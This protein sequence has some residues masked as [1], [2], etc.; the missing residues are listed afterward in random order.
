MDE[1]V[2]GSGGKPDGPGAAAGVKETDETDAA[3]VP[4]DPVTLTGP[5]AGTP[6]YISPELLLGHPVGPAADVWAFGCVLFEC[7]A[8]VSPFSAEGSATRVP[9][10]FRKAMATLDLKP[11]WS[12]LPEGLSAGVGELLRA[13]LGTEPADRPDSAAVRRSLEGSLRKFEAPTLAAR[14]LSRRGAVLVACL[15]AVIVGAVMAG[16]NRRPAPI[17]LPNSS[18]RQL[19]FRGNTL[20]C[21]LAPDGETAAFLDETGRLAYL[22]LQAGDERAAQLTE[23]ASGEPISIIGAR[24]MDLRWAPNGRELAV[25]GVRQP[26]LPEMSTYLVARDGHLAVELD[27]GGFAGVVW[28]PDGERIAGTRGVGSRSEL[29]IVERRTGRR[30]EVPL[31][32]KIR[33]ALVLD[34]TAGDQLFFRDVENDSVYVVPAGGG[35]PRA[36]MKGSWLRCLPARNEVC[37][38]AENQLRLAALGPGGVPAAAYTVLA[39][40]LPPFSSPFSLARDGRRI[41]YNSAPMVEVWLG[42]RASAA[43]GGDGFRWNR[44]VR[45]SISTY[46]AR[47][48]P[49]GSKVAFVGSPVGETARFLLVHSLEDGSRMVAA[50]DTAINYPDWSPDGTE[51]VYRNA[52]GMA[53]VGLESASPCQVPGP[54][55]PMYI[56]WLPDGCI[57]YMEGDGNLWQAYSQLD[58]ASGRITRLP[59]DEERGTLLQ[60]AVAP[61][62]K[63]LAVAGN[64]GEQADVKVWLVDLTDGSERLLYDDWA[65]P[66]DWSADGRWVYLVT[67]HEPALSDR[68]RS[69]VLRVAVADLAVEQVTDLPEPAFTWDH[70]DLSRDGRRIAF[71]QRRTGRDL[72]LMDI[73]PTRR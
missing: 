15:M 40:R 10:R 7:L 29:C 73:E 12:S 28:S 63:S 43:A 41:L 42:E 35:R 21:D 11:D 38:R 64:R 65:A 61:D 47:F 5:I 37:Y 20:A 13:C 54:R 31:V 62:G 46:A 58:P 30:Q 39:D 45:E 57:V 55:D 69:Q 66:F 49:D 52:R 34:W 22:D 50:R 8:G 17:G 53:R 56:R 1:R 33:P 18:A 60:F 16:R 32:G 14:L 23:E 44:L 19:T 70:I 6:G 72:W 51:L 36:V 2:E 4:A 59:I 25:I 48:S 71:D 67:E 26:A 3:A 68:R 24:S 9:T 27:G